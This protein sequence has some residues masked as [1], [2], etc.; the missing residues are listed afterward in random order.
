MVSAEGSRRTG[1]APA[2]TVLAGP[3]A[4]L[5]DEALRAL[6]SAVFSN[7]SEREL[8]RHLFRASETPLADVIGQALTAPFLA[9]KRLVVLDEADA[10][11]RADR[12]LLLRHLKGG[13]P[14]VW[15]VLTEE[16]N[17][18]RSAFLAELGRLGRVV[19]CQAPYRDTDIARWAEARA[20]RL[21]KALDGE[22]A[23]LLVERA[24]RN[25]TDLASRLEALALYVKG[26]AIGTGDVEALVGE[27][28]SRTAF[29]LSDALDR[30]D[31]ASAWRTLRRLLDEG[32]RPHEILGAL[33]WR[34]DRSVR[35]KNLKDLGQGFAEA[36]AALGVSRAFAGEEW[37]AAGRLG[38]ARAE[39]KLRVL[40]ESDSRLKRGLVEPVQAAEGCVLA[41]NEV[42]AA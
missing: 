41:L 18:A 22:A 8:N 34:F 5:R 7:P 20:R 42:E 29:Y 17:A 32:A 3:E 1:A 25:L 39:G 21:G 26:P 37:A 15:A 12:E 24:G 30:R 38:R 10:L 33:A 16:A 28:V 4:V 19:P 35:L 40:W 6:E 14:A 13:T 11:A 9:P 27:S 23:A 2:V 36:T 31:F